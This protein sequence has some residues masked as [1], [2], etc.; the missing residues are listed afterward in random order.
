[1]LKQEMK[2]TA[3]HVSSILKKREAKVTELR[4]RVLEQLSR[5]QSEAALLKK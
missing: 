5:L 1:M 2:E 4:K 3:S